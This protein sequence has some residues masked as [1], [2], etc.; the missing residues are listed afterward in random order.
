MASIV[1]VWQGAQLVNASALPQFNQTSGM[2]TRSIQI[3]NDS[4][5]AI[6]YRS[7]RGLDIVI[8]ARYQLNAPLE[9]NSQYSISL[10][11]GQIGS[12]AAGQSVTCSES[13]QESTYQSSPLTAQAAFLTIQSARV[14]E[15]NQ[16][17]AGQA[18]WSLTSFAAS[19][20]K[21]AILRVR[22]NGQVRGTSPGQAS[23][24]MHVEVTDSWLG[25]WYP[26][27]IFV[28]ETLPAHDDKVYS[29]PISPAALDETRE[30]IIAVYV[31]ALVGTPTVDLEAEVEWVI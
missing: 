17:V 19:A 11:P 1:T 2:V 29:S 6:V 28:D 30:W 5:V 8:S 27:T 31:T 15:T 22:V 4:D 13:Q 7:E 3:S 24:V 25:I 20:Q 18:N 16:I 21:P 26:T 12:G 10:A 14:L 23:A 9:A